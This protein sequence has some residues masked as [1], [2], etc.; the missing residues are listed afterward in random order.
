VQELVPLAFSSPIQNP[1]ELD[2]T[3]PLLLPPL[4]SPPTTTT[5]ATNKY[6]HQVVSLDT[7]LAYGALANFLH[8][9]YLA[10]YPYAE[11]CMF[12]FC[13]GDMLFYGVVWLDG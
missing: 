1:F 4:Q 3:I 6:H 10:N 13:D 7:F 8:K 11:L 5:F 9:V 12:L 2:R